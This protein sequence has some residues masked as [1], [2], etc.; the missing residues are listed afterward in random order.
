MARRNRAEVVVADEIGVYHCVQRVVRRAFLCGVDP[1]SGNSHERGHWGHPR[2]EAQAELWG[3]EFGS[4]AEGSDCANPQ[5]PPSR[6]QRERCLTAITRIENQKSLDHGAPAAK[7]PDGMIARPYA[8]T[9]RR[10]V[11][12]TSASLAR[13][14]EDLLPDVIGQMHAPRP[15]ELE[16][17]PDARYD[18]EF[19]CLQEKAKRS[20]L[21]DP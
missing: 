4:N 8:F 10:G 12:L 7:P 2:I 19:L 20:G 6:R 3:P 21:G 9:S 1:R 5:H 14:R 11:P 16:W 18:P 13:Q 17:D 15:Q